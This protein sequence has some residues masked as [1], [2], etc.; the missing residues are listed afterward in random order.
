MRIGTAER[1]E[2]TRVLGQHFADGRLSTEEYETR[3]TAAVQANTRADL[4]TLFEDLPTP[5]PA[6]LLP[7]QPPVW[8]PPAV[9]QPPAYR[10]GAVVGPPSERS[11]IVAGVLQ[12][13]LPFGVGRF[14][15]GHT[16]MAV[17]Q[18]LV[19]FFTFGVGAIW[20]FIDGILLLVNGGTDPQGR[21][22]RG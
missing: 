9:S 18:L 3:V 5:H 8:A 6:F 16:K 2:A 15:T 20:P 13:V 7:P 11:K 4:R 14:Y 19:T 17:A 12:I 21:P 1:E 10:Q 22:L